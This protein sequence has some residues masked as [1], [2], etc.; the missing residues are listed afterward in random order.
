MMALLKM[1]VTFLVYR[2]PELDTIRVIEK[3][4]PVKK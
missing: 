3:R 4:F 2:F 1:V